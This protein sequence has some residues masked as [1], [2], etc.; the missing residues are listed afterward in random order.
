[1]RRIEVADERS[2]DLNGEVRP[3]RAT[4]PTRRSFAALDDDL[5][6]IAEQRLRGNPAARGASAFDGDVADRLADP[7]RRR[8]RGVP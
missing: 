5:V 6:V 2:F 4:P 7:V 3:R 8:R 1:M